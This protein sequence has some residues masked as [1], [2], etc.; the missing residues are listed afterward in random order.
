MPV[1]VFLEANTNDDITSLAF[2]TVHEGASQK[3]ID[4]KSH[5]LQTTTVLT[6]RY[7]EKRD[8]HRLRKQHRKQTQAVSVRVRESHRRQCCKPS[9][10]E[11]CQNP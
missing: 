9:R 11:S 10:S 1:L 6:K 5:T 8:V 7:D 2:D 3:Q 4:E